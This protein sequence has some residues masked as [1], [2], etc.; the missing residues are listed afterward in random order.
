MTELIG[1]SI[2]HYKIIEKIAEARPACADASCL[3]CVSRQAAGLP[4]EGAN[5]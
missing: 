4:V 5:E 1:Q 3:T 2:S